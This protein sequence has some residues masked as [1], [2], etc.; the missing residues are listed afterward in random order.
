M[1]EDPKTITGE[2]KPNTLVENLGKRISVN[3]GR[4][5]FLDEGQSTYPRVSELLVIVKV[6]SEMEI[7]DILCNFNN[8]NS[9]FN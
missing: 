5:E 8:N 7:P 9:D 1:S 3:N 4:I 2:P 6:I